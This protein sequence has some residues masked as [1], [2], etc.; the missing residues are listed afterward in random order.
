MPFNT[1]LLSDCLLPDK[2]SF[3][4]NQA[5]IN[6]QRQP[7][8]TILFFLI[9]P[10]DNPNCRLRQL[11]KLD[12][13]KQ[14]IC[15]LLVFYAKDSERIICF[16][17]LKGKDLSGAT[18]QVI[19]THEKFKKLLPQNSRNCKY[20]TKAFIILTGSVPKEHEQCQKRLSETFGEKNYYHT[21]RGEDLGKFLR[22]EPRKM[23]GK[24]KK[25]DR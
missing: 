23:K 5:S 20:Q 2:T 10:E 24:R 8:E 19:Q 9:D 11:L 4:Q 22:E 1:L 16:V 25:R 15:D 13:E 14:K 6:I 3:K 12:G 21:R 7:G 17:E 18:E